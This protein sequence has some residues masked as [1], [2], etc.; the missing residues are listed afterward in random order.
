MPGGPARKGARS[1]LEEAGLEVAVAAEPYAATVSFAERPADLVVLDLGSFRPRDRAFLRV[2]RRRSPAVRVLLLL[3]E[4][5][6]RLAVT[7]LEAGADA[8]VLEPFHPGELAAVARGLLR[9]RI[10]GTL[11]SDPAALIRLSNEVAHAVNNPLQVLSLAAEAS[12]PRGTPKDPAL[13]D[14]VGRIKDVVGL[15]QAYGRLGP[16][17][18]Q[19]L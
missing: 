3:P 16:P 10:G 14:T 8:Y 12:T 15:L 19:P 1:A 7:A 5:R 17:Q 11:G 6:R 4:G 13:Q 2:V 9:D 18:R